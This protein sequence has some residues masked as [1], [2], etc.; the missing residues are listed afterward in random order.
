VP[1]TIVK[2]ATGT[3]V[4]IY[5]K[6]SW[7]TTHPERQAWSKI[8]LDNIT[9]N[10]D[11]LNKAQDINRFCPKYG[12]ALT[13]DQ[14]IN[15]LGELFVALAFYESK[16]T[17]N[18]T[19]QDQG[20]E[21]D[22]ETYSDGLFQVSGADWENYNLQKVLPHYLHKDLLTV[23]PNIKL[24]MALMSQQIT[25]QGLICVSSNVYWATLSDKFY[26]P[27]AVISEISQRVQKLSFCK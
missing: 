5:P 15:V 21:G 2:D 25:K 27:Y 24:A 17:P 13:K 16:W 26:H 6:L 20:D 11:V 3:L 4:G 7:E 22:L 10:F 1:K 14:K 12:N 9:S 18:E 8:L 19:D 23:E